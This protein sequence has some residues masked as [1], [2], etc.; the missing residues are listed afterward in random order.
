MSQGVIPKSPRFYQRAEGSPVAHSFVAGDPSLR[1]KNGYAQDDA[2]DERRCCQ[3]TTQSIADLKG[4]GFTPRRLS[5]KWPGAS[6]PRWI[7]T[8]WN[9]QGEPGTSEFQSHGPV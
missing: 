4:R 3:T 2:I 5:P 8:V 7:R 9:G 1:L 6:A